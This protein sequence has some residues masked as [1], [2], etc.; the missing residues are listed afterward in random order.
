MYLTLQI[1][2]L[3]GWGDTLE[4]GSTFSDRR[5]EVGKRLWEEVTRR[6]SSEQDVK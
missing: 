2:N 6:R 3:P 5:R 1:L 4:D